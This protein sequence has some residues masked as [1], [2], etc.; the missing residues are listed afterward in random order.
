MLVSWCISVL[1]YQL[2]T[3]HRNLLLHGSF[4]YRQHFRRFFHLIHR[5]HVHFEYSR[6]WST[7]W[8][9]NF[10][11]T[12][13]LTLL[14]MHHHTWGTVLLNRV[15]GKFVR[16]N[17]KLLGWPLVL[18]TRSW[19]IRILYGRCRRKIR[20]VQQL[21]VLLCGLG[22]TLLVP[23]GEHGSCISELAHL[24]C[25]LRCEL[26]SRIR[27]CTQRHGLLFYVNILRRLP[28]CHWVLTLGDLRIFH[29]AKSLCLVIF[30]GLLMLKW[31]SRYWRSELWLFNYRS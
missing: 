19:V 15:D 30:G 26:L 18:I 7:L 1:A 16:R 28:G 4:L 14:M 9:E 2:T 17:G 27:Y 6:C 11:V 31:W 22:S 13:R 29:P 10:W 8:H 12:L 20:I 21:L 23:A 5:S 25:F 3:M 24:L